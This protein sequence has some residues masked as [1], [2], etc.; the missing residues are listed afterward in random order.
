MH[1]KIFIAIMQV[2][3]SVTICKNLFK[4]L[5]FVATFKTCWTFISNC[6]INDRSN[7]FLTTRPF[8]FKQNIGF[9]ESEENLAADISVYYL[10]PSF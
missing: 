10:L 1:R 8:H 9:P 7:S 4:V 6:T 2:D 3:K 5:N